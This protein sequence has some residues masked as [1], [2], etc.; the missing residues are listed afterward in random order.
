MI[1][2]KVTYKINRQLKKFIHRIKFYFIKPIIGVD[3][4]RDKD[5][6]VIVKLKFVDKTLHI[7]DFKEI[8]NV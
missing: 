2:K 6:T 4:A 5:S 8:K 7:V 1:Y 3:I